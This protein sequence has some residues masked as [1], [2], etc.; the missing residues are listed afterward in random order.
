MTGRG[1][2]L[3][4]DWYVPVAQLP[5][6][7]LLGGAGAGCSWAVVR[8]GG[9]G[10]RSLLQLVIASFERRGHGAASPVKGALPLCSP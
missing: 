8:R 1:W 2:Q 10:P 4:A 7:E 9:E 3:G 6:P 5:L